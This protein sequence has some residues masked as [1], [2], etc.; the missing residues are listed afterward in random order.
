[1]IS[2]PPF[3]F[4]VSVIKNYEVAINRAHKHPNNFALAK[5]NAPESLT[6]VIHVDLFICTM[7]IG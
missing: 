7:L 1:M 6:S 3:V 4:P 2:L 5:L